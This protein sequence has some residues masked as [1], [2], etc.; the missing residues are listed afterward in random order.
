MPSRSERR[1][2]ERGGAPSGPS[3]F[4][5]RQ[6]V[7]AAA[8]GAVL[9]AGLLAF[10]L[11]SDGGGGEPSDQQSIEALAKESIE[12]L[13]R[14]EWPSLYDDFTAGVPAAMP[15]TGFRG[16]G[17]GRRCRTRREALTAAI[18]TSRGRIDTGRHR[19]RDRLW[20]RSPARRSIVYGAPSREWMAPGSWRPPRTPPAARPSIES[21]HDQSTT[22]GAQNR[23]RPV[24]YATGRSL[25]CTA[26]GGATAPFCLP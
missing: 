1:R 14:G 13:P 4:P 7:I 16:C 21:L 19:D 25:L 24:L 9:L 10:L 26:R 3:L 2:R 17:A 11:F 23:D 20:A 5:V 6:L 22:T 12:V 18:R 8:I 15:A